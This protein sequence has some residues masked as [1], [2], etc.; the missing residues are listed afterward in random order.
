MINILKS[1]SGAIISF[2]AAII[3]VVVSVISG[4]SLVAI[5]Q[6]DQVQTQYQQDMLQEEL[7]L[8]SDAARTLFSLE[9]SRPILERRVEVLEPHRTTSYTIK[10]I[11]RTISIENF[12]GFTTEQAVAVTSTISAKRSRLFSSQNVSPIKRATERYLRRESLAQFQYFTDQESSENVDGGTEAGAVKFWG[13]DVLNGPVHSNDDI[14]IQQAGGG[15]NGGWPTFYDHVTTSGIFRKYPTGIHLV[16]SGAPMDQI[17][18]GP[19]P[20]WLEHV[21]GIIFEPNAND[22]RAN[23]IRPFTGL[24]ADIVHVTISSSTYESWIGRYIYDGVQDFTVY[25][26]YPA[27]ANQANTIINAG[28]NWFEDA[29]SIWTNRIPIYNLEWTP[30]P[31]GSVINRCVWVDEGQLWIQGSVGGKQTWG[32][33]DTVFIIGDITYEHTDPGDPPDDENN[34]NRQDYFGLVSEKRILVKYKHRDPESGDVMSPNCND[35]YMYGAFAAIGL[36][37]GELASHWDGIFSYEYQHPHGSTPNF[38]ALSPYTLQETTYTYVDFHKFIYPIMPFVPPNISGFNLHGNQPPDNLP[39][40]YNYES[41]GYLNSYPN[42]ANGNPNYN[43]ATPYGTDWPWLNPIWPENRQTIVFERGTLHIFGA[44]AQRRRGF[45]HR[46]GTDPYN[47][48][49]QMEWDLAAFHYD[50]THP[51]TGY[52]KDYFYD[53][54]FLFVQPPCYPEV[55]RGFGSEVLTSF[56]EESW[57]FVIPD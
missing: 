48:P 51:S 27:N 32:C 38:T 37:E 7:L 6:T 45:V 30:G 2:V 12:M 21:P 4:L 14:W 15:N 55:Y 39:C 29:D 10:S 25:S 16:D 35:V 34:L 56:Q 33:A 52:A 49:D 43:Y 24:D 3:V 20:A 36:G 9:L 5:V 17:F 44:I 19:E 46:S 54:R 41:A 47:H 50:G 28:Y 18:Q 57:F 13:P 40:G 1:E 26:W 11:Q 23:G 22:I 8:R 53:Q 42:S 31:S